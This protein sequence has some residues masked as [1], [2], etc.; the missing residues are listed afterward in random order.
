MP[1]VTGHAPG[2]PSWVELDTN[3]E[4]GALA[5]YS[6]V[7]GWVDDPQPI[8]DTWTYHM[9]RI[10]G[11]EAAAIYQMSEEEAG[12]NIPPH[13]TTYLTCDNADAV[14][15]RTTQLGG[16]ILFGPMDVFE[17]GRMAMLQDPQ[18][19]AFAVWQPKQ[20]IGC[21]IKD[22]PGAMIWNELMTSDRD[23]AIGFYNG[24]LGIE[25][26]GV[27]GPMDYTLIKAGGYEVGGVMEITADM[28]PIPPLL[29]GLLR[30]RRC[31]RDRGQGPIPG[32]WSGRPRHRNP[33]HRAFRLPNRPPGRPLQ[34][35]QRRLT[36]TPS[37]AGGNR[38][39]NPP[40]RS[41]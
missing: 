14:A 32:R 12:Q 27:M 11:L 30:R 9:Q 26:G 6:A 21:R 2:T 31:R 36:P 15:G 33:R 13:W 40:A 34:H 35:F 41:S 7:F 37:G 23:A 5:F 19:A 10:D 25:H 17:A 38:P 24:I 16:S 18:G 22:D 8:T 3:D 20:H 1:E 4:T 29:G 39:P 28:G